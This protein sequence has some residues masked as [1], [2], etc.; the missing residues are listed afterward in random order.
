[1]VFVGNDFEVFVLQPKLLLLFAVNYCIVARVILDLYLGKAARLR[2]CSHG[3]SHTILS[4]PALATY[5][6][7]IMMGDSSPYLAAPRAWC[8]QL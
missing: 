2:A 1:M 6:L 7:L 4:H 5:S 8:S 3:G